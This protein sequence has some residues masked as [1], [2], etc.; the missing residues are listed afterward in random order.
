MDEERGLPYN[1]MTAN[2]KRILH[3]EI[4]IWQLTIV[5]IVWGK[6]HQKI[7]ERISI[8]NGTGGYEM[9]TPIHVALR[10]EFEN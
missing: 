4:A 2:V 1:R 3:L 7:Y 8:Q 9:G 6:S 5:V 10:T